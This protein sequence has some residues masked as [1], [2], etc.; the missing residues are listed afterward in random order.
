[1]SHVLEWPSP[2]MTALQ[3]SVEREAHAAALR[4]LT[5]AGIP[6]TVGGYYALRYYTDVFRSTKDLDIFV[7]PGQVPAALGVLREEGFK[8][9]VLASHWLAK[10]QWQGWW[11]DVVFGFGNWLASVD[12]LWVERAPEAELFGVRVRMAPIEEMIWI[13]AFVFHRERYH[14]NDVMHL[15]W[16]G[17]PNMDWKHLVNRFNEHWE[18][19][20]A[21]VV[22]F[23]Y[24][25]PSDSDRIPRWVQTHLMERLRERWKS[26]PVRER[27]CRGVVLDRYQYLHDVLVH[28]FHDAREELARNL[29]FPPQMVE[30]DRR[31]ALHMLR[32]GR[33]RPSPG[34]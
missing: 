3:V 22:L 12:D 24:V 25:Y 13:K 2:P 27:V 5:D 19:L 34:H 18:V 33:V 10:A 28:G 16:A 30:K 11:V 4:R 6:F 9:K 32:A 1:M 21:L 14:G 20:A 23:R 17:G 31:E 26:P 15:M 29:G 8:T 7:V